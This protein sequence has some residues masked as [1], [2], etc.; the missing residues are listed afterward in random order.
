MK[1]TLQQILGSEQ[2]SEIG[3]KFLKSSTM[4]DLCAVFGREQEIIERQ[5]HIKANEHLN[6]AKVKYCDFLKFWF[7][8]MLL[9]F[10]VG[11]EK[12][13]IRQQIPVKL[14]S[15]LSVS[16]GSGGKEKT[17][18]KLSSAIGMKQVRKFDC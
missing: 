3:K 4:R 14:S 5:A 2:D 6:E 16:G 13:E 12:P 17:S 1:Y 18:K 7:N 9:K 10:Q 8:E 11:V 15:K